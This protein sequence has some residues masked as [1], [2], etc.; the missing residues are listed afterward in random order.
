MH[1]FYFWTTPMICCQRVFVE[2]QPYIVYLLFRRVKI[3]FW[4]EVD[5]QVESFFHRENNNCHYDL[6]QRFRYYKNLWKT[7][8]FLLCHTWYYIFLY[9]TMYICK[10]LYIQN[11]SCRYMH[12]F[13]ILK[14]IYDIVI[15]HVLHISWK[16]T[17]PILS[18]STFYHGT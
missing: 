18:F 15:L 4:D 3:I 9:C 2:F 12:S 17:T 7:I 14:I 1:L 6:H 8:F 16:F 10:I 5:F 11:C 13:L